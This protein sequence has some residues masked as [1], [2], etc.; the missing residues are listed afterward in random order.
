MIVLKVLE[1]D[2][3]C[4]DL[5]TH[6]DRVVPAGW[7]VRSARNA[8][9]TVVAKLSIWQAWRLLKLK[10]P[11][12]WPMRISLG[13]WEWTSDAAQGACEVGGTG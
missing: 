12:Y 10:R 8:R 11:N 7:W 5:L 9:W 1:C 3:D 4:C 13:R 6:R 2:A